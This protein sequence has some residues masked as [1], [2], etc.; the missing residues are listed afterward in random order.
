MLIATA[1]HVDHGKTTLVNALTGVD[2]DRLPEEK[3]RGLTIDLGFAYAAGP[4]ETTFGFVDVPG[5]EKF[6]RNM[7]AGVGAI[8]VA[9]LVVAADDGVMPQTREHVAILDLFGISSCIVAITRTD[10]VD[11]TVVQNVSAQV[12]AL[13][14]GTTLAGAVLMP[15]S[16]PSGEGIAELKESLFDI[17]RK[18]AASVAEELFRL[19]VDRSFTVRGAGTVVTGA[20]F[21]GTVNVGDSVKVLP[22]GIDSRVRGIHADGAES[23]AATAGQRAALNLTGVETN[24]TARGMW[25]VDPAID[26]VSTC[27]DVKVRILETE[28]RPFRHWTPVHVHSGA[29]SFTGRVA[30]YDLRNIE[31]GES[32]YGQL[33]LDSP[34]HLIF[35]DRFVLRDQGATRTVGG[36][37]VVDPFASRHR[38]FRRG[39]TTVLKALDEPDVGRALDQVLNTASTG[40]DEMQFRQT[41]NLSLD[42]MQRV[43]AD[44]GAARIDDA[45]G[46]SKLVNRASLNSMTEK[47]HQALAS[48]HEETPGAVGLEP[49]ALH[50]LISASGSLFEAALGELLR[51]GRVVREGVRLKLPE[52]T[53]RLSDEEQ[54]LLD[55]ILTLVTSDMIKPPPLS[56]LATALG[57]ERPELSTR[58][59]ALARAGHIVRVAEN[60]VFHPGALDILADMA[61]ELAQEHGKQG[62]DAKAFRD[63]T[64]I[65][66][67]IS[68]DVLEYFDTAGLTRRLADRRTFRR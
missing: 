2:T 50:K 18:H 46:V 61:R 26:V 29:S 20:V 41:R 3:E 15:V 63:R 4:G 47:I 23:N 30:L 59:T 37:H 64:G 1:G 34:A 44:S 8:D 21:S 68:I 10:L 53:V 40:I 16:A 62:F 60:R 39:R 28:S 56:E 6:V 45:S 7:A 17:A 25:V 35:G 27:V 42:E 11:S 32:G 31:P 49:E 38:S 67:N 9:L 43:V 22:S 33:V 51:T 48:F 54:Q 55:K 66:R 12:K 5:H 24:E 36:G 14:E 19:S 52:H 65:G 57:I 13:L 58:V